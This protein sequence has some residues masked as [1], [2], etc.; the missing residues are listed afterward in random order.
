M[1]ENHQYILDYWLF[2]NSAP[3]PIHSQCMCDVA[4]YY[5]YFSKVLLLPFKKLIG[6]KDHLQKDTLK[7]P[8]YIFIPEY[9]P[10]QCGY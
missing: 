1:E 5:A 4:T 7:V 9:A 3:K 6:E 8:W 2:T 10:D